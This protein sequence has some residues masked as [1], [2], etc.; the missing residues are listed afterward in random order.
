MRVLLPIPAIGDSGLESFPL[1]S[2]ASIAEGEIV[3]TAIGVDGN[4]KGKEGTPSSP[5]S[6]IV[7]N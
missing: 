4:G 3:L 1:S 5:S 7:A 2:S 6:R